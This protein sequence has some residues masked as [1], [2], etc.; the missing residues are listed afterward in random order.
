MSVL[1]IVLPRRI[2][3]V[4]LFFFFYLGL[5]AQEAPSWLTSPEANRWADSV[6]A[7]LK[8]EERIAQSFMLVGYA[9]GDKHE[10]KAIL[11]L[12]EKQGVGG[13]MFLQGNRERMRTLTETYQ[14]KSKVPLLFALDA[15]WGTDMRLEDG[16]AYPKAMGL[17]ATGMPALAYRMGEEVANELQEMGIHINFAPVVDVQ[18]NPKNP[19][20]GVRAFSDDVQTISQFGVAYMAGMQSQGLLA[21]AKHFPGHGNTSTDSHHTLPIV[22]AK[23]AQLDTCDLIPFRNLIDEGLSMVM[24]A[25][26]ALPGLGL[27]DS[28]PASLRHEVTTTLLRDSL[29]FQGLICTDALNMKGAT[30]K[31]KP[32]EVALQA[33]LAGADIL[34]CPDNV[35]GGIKAIANAVKHKKITEAE[36]NLRAKRLL[37]AKYSAVKAQQERIATVAQRTTSE[38]A[39]SEQERNDLSARIAQE[40]V[41]LLS[42]GEST[43]PIAQLD[44]QN[45]GY[46]SFLPKKDDTFLSGLQRYAAIYDE[47]QA[48]TKGVLDAQIKAATKDKT[49]MI[50][51][52][53]ATGYAPSKNFGVSKEQIAFA[54][55]CAKSKPTILV[56][57]GSP[58]VQARFFPLTDFAAVL[59]AYDDTRFSQDAV[60]QIIFGALPA[61]GSF[62]ISL[63][64]DL[65]LGDGIR[66]EGGLRLS[67]VSPTQHGANPLYIA[68][69]DSLAQA[70]IDS[71]AFPGIQILAYHKGEVFYRRNFGR[72]TYSKFS[73]PVT[74][75]TIYDLASVTKITATTP[76]VMRLVEKKKLR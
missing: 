43:I 52:V 39:R 2:F 10:D 3:F 5:R 40:A 71:G 30:G 21:C 76:L 27:P 32:E 15:E 70:G 62:P 66:T 8:L 38:D 36:V 16:L 73:P 46:V 20:I 49:L 18:R 11:T 41:T 47:K 12:V 67:Y 53:R 7:T 33:Y 6:L 50:V 13:V 34:L 28:V 37:L 58:Y 29:G 56:V 24:V 60:S 22:K 19:V 48:L 26:I 64:P 54:K 35:A 57:F 69:A 9:R 75:T 65:H 59:Q 44:K 14:A 51:A 68:R 45:I 42:N 17:A 31:L 63:P 4:G 61:L 74:D 23:Y 72:T 1:R 25:H 55:A